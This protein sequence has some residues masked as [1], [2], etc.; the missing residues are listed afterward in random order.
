MTKLVF[1]TTYFNEF[2]TTIKLLDRL[3]DNGAFLIFGD[4]LLIRGVNLIN[5]IAT[6]YTWKGDFFHQL[7]IKSERLLYRLEITDFDQFAKRIANIPPSFNSLLSLEFDVRRQVLDFWCHGK[8]GSVYFDSITF[9]KTATDDIYIDIYPVGN[10]KVIY[11]TIG[12]YFMSALLGF[13]R[14]SKDISITLTPKTFRLHV[15][16]KGIVSPTIYF[17]LDCNDQTPSDGVRLTKWEL[18]SKFYYRVFSLN[19]L[20]KSNFGVSSKKLIC[21]ETIEEQ[22]TCMVYEDSVRCNVK[23]ITIDSIREPSN[24]SSNNGDINK[25]LNELI[26][27][28]GR[29]GMKLNEIINILPDIVNPYI[30]SLL[31]KKITEEYTF[32]C[33]KKLIVAEL[34]KPEVMTNNIEEELEE[35]EMLDTNDYCSM[36]QTIN[37]IFELLNQLD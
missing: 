26:T 23:I 19:G 20:L 5:N 8:G 14:L 25:K 32:Y 35:D 17:N 15:D 3:I 18:N 33:K 24:I 7:K 27:D 28:G 6:Q 21:F 12:K 4:K 22:S 31:E 30:Q 9:E 13:R 37:P 2:Q 34:I 16:G 36:R 1:R 11:S 29:D 10:F